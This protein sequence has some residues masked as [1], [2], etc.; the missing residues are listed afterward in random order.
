MLV[1]TRYNSWLIL[2]YYQPRNV[3]RLLQKLE[4]NYLS[5]QNFAK[6]EIL[7]VIWP[8]FFLFQCCSTT[9]LHKTHR[10]CFDVRKCKLRSLASLWG[11]DRDEVTVWVRGLGGSVMSRWFGFIM[12]AHW[13][14]G[15]RYLYSGP[16]NFSESSLQKWNQ[17]EKRLW[18]YS[19]ILKWLWHRE[20]VDEWQRFTTSHA[21]AL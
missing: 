2:K 7:S 17:I 8:V 11:W 6:T 1:S 13:W 21:P 12:V 10:S 4:R 20:N 3:K 18:V 9:F 14:L 19:S 16:T 15:L 5:R